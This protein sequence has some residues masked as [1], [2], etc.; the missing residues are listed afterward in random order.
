MALGS[1]GRE[2]AQRPTPWRR[3]RWLGKHGWLAVPTVLYAVLRIPSFLEPHWYTDE[4]GY[5]TTARS[6]LQ[7]HRLYSQIWT[8]K[9]P[10]EI[11]TTAIL[12]RLLGESEAALHAVS[13]V[14]CLIALGAVAYAADRILGRKRA[15]IA[16]LLGAVLLGAPFFDAELFLPESLLIAPATWAGAI[17]VTRIGQP[18]RRAWPRW[19]AAAGALV[20]LAVGF[21]QTALADAICFGFLLVLLAAPPPGSRR[22]RVAVYAAA[23]LA[24]TAA[25]LIPSL[26]VAGAS[27]LGYA[28]VGF[29]FAFTRLQSSTGA[30][31]VLPEL[32]LLVA[33]LAI[34]LGSAFIRRRAGDPTLPLWV[35]A[36]ATL[37][38]P[39]AARQPYAHYLVPSIAPGV[40]AVTSLG[41]GW[42]RRA[43]SAA[44]HPVALRGSRL[45]AAGLVAATGLALWGA[46][47]AGWDWTLMPDGSVHNLADYYG[48]AYAVLTRTRSLQ[49]WQDTFD[50]R[51]PEDRQ[52]GMWISN[53]GLRGS[54]AV[55][56][57][58]DAWLYDVD[59]LELL[60]P[61]PPI[62]NVEV[63]LGSDLQVGA[64]VAS[65]DPQLIVTEGSAR[66]ALPSI[67]GVL[68][69]GYAAMA[70]S[71]DGNEIVWVRDDLAAS[72]GAAQTGD[73]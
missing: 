62:Y 67:N 63:L 70:R 25:W 59:D 16:L 39:A 20:A 64:T 49:T 1:R 32:I 6:V 51:V 68:S 69:A 54:S 47:A 56:W 58:A 10:I 7:G 8:N 31:G 23:F 3:R 33:V 15:G 42:R 4:A 71:N 57:S 24:V 11:W 26:A 14:T 45:G 55:V 72:I 22:R 35:W 50:Y 13:F 17:L 66:S 73:G 36:A 52:V 18:E 61:T 2:E 60:L 53:H 48:G 34:G 30:V 40:L 21:Q 37:L 46:S 12:T 65:L 19:P 44:D 43:A 5:V 9:P 41:R 29:Y 27:T 38:V 28:L